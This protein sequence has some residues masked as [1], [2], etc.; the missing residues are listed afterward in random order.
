MA[1]R[2]ARRVVDAAEHRALGALADQ[3]GE[4]PRGVAMAAAAG[5]V[6]RIGQHDEARRGDRLR[7]ALRDRQDIADEIALMRRHPGDQ[8]IGRGIGRG[9][10]LGEGGDR[11]AAALEVAVGKAEAEGELGAAV[12]GGEPRAFRHRRRHRPLQRALAGDGGEV[13]DAAIR[14]RPGPAAPD[15]LD[16]QRRRPRPRR[17]HVDM[18]IGAVGRDGVRQGDHRRRQVGMRVEA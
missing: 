13:V 17:M 4:Q 2:G 10:V 11:G 18:R 14:P 3:F 5:I 9:L 12:Q 16:R 6:L 15:A 7:H 8:R 1:G